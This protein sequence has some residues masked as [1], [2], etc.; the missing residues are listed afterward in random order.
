MMYMAVGMIV[1]WRV[2]GDFI[3]GIIYL[4]LDIFR[5]HSCTRKSI[6]SKKAY[7]KSGSILLQDDG[8]RDFIAC[9]LPTTLASLF[10]LTPHDFAVTCNL[11]VAYMSVV[12]KLTPHAH[13]TTPHL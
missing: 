7:L 5:R 6:L 2:Y 8:L 11:L 12:W 13:H 10:D 4:F 3:N 1:S 9:F